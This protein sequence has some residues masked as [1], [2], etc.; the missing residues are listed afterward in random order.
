MSGYQVEIE[1]LG[2]LIQTL[3]T[4]AD[5][6]TDANNRLKDAS[7][8]DLGSAELDRAGGDFQDRWEHGT[9]KL[10]E[11]AGNVT[12]G[13]QV[14]KKAYEEIEKALTEV[15]STMAGAFSGGGSGEGSGNSE[16]SSR[17]GGD[18]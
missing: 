18:A 8:S 3:E 4:A 16:I 10:A 6:I 5:S 13:M 1:G 11:A 14:T 17:L 9:K 2:R 7:P 15:F 12:E